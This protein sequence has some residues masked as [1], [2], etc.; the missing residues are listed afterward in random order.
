[1]LR[2]TS[3][4]LPSVDEAVRSMSRHGENSGGVWDPRRADATYEIRPDKES[5][6]WNMH[7]PVIYWWTSTEVDEKTAYII[8][9]DG[10][11]W[12]RNKQNRPG[13][14]AFRAVKEKDPGDNHERAMTRLTFEID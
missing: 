12:R 4:R 6:L 10:R 7:S 14:R 1:M 8:V 3:V 2:R 11:V 13:Y 9:Y 5:P